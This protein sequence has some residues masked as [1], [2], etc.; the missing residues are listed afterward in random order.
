MFEPWFQRPMFGSIPQNHI[1]VDKSNSMVKW[2]DTPF[3]SKVKSSQLI[4]NAP[5]K[6]LYVTLN[7]MENFI[8]SEVGV[9]EQTESSTSLATI[10]FDDGQEDNYISKTYLCLLARSQTSEMSPTECVNVFIIFEP[11][12]GPVEGK[13]FRRIGI[14]SYW[15][16]AFNFDLKDKRSIHWI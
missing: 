2:T 16:S 4:V 13:S 9:A 8:V 6:E 5:M 10:I 3:V 1:E 14:G 7:E 12:P 11:A 15:N